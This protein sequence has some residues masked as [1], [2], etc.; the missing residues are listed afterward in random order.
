M[1]NHEKADNSTLPISTRILLPIGFVLQRGPAMQPQRC[2][3]SKVLMTVRDR[4]RL[5]IRLQFAPG[6]NGK[7]L[8]IDLDESAGERLVD[9]LAQLVDPLAPGSES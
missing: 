4:G 8:W 6:K 1:T 3:A 7:V 9:C 5:G 2:V